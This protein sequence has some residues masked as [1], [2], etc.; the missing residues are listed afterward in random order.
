MT[1]PG[2]ATELPRDLASLLDAEGASVT[3]HREIDHG[4]QYRISLGPDTA[5]LNLY[6]T[7]KTLVQ[8]KDSKLKSLLQGYSGTT[9]RPGKKSASRTRPSA[10]VDA[11]PRVGTD[12]AGKGDYFGPLVVAGVRVLG[13]REARG[14]RDVGVR[15]SKELTDA[16]MKRMSAE[17]L[18]L[19]GQ[20]NVRVVVLGPP[21]YEERRRAAGDIN[22]LLG[23]VN[24]GILH[25]LEDDVE[26]FVVDQFAKAARSYIQPGVPG[27]VRLEVRPRAE[28]DAAV[29]AASILARARYVGELERLSGEVGYR[30]PLGATHVL[31]AARRVYREGGMRALQKVAKTHFKTTEKVTR[32]QGAKV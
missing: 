19:V 17:I 32:D 30:L 23:E 2:A 8:G 10:A 24:V 18:A 6:R 3:N 28:D 25:E 27:G 5:N 16:A 26:R 11:T 22:R 14:L 4:T 15:D 1:H 20:E 9:A 31:P 13:E 21:E 29:A 7:G 12:E